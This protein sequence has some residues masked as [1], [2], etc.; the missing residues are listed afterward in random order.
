MNHLFINQKELI[1]QSIERAQLKLE[2]HKELG[3]KSPYS[4]FD[5]ATMMDDL[6]F[7][8]TQKRSERQLLIS[9]N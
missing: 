1:D 3:A 9:K 8:K 4:V 7:N 5:I 2:Q 6:R